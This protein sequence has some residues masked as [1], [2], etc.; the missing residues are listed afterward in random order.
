MTC[1]NFTLICYVLLTVYWSVSSFGT[2]QTVY[3]QHPVIRWLT[4]GAPIVGYV[5]I[6]TPFL[7]VGWLG[8]RFLPDSLP[9]RLAG[10]CACV[11]GLA[12]AVWSRRTIGANWSGIVTLKQDHELVQTG[13]YALA[14]HPIYTG[15]MLAIL[16]TAVVSGEMRAI[17]AVAITAIGFANKIVAEEQVMMREFPEKY[18]QYKKRVK[19]IVPFIY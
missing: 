4:W 8:H 5:L 11:A 16:G 6:F 19:R 9:L 2:K 12:F 3:Q 1:L 17:L 10:T 14:R 13:P 7:G 15:C 18:P